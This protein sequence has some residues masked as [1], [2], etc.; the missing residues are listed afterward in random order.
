LI[1]RIGA[2]AQTWHPPADGVWLFGSA[3][4]GEGGQD[5]D[6]DLLVIRNE[7]VDADDSLWLVQLE[8]LAQSVASWTGNDCR[9][10]EYSVGEIVR[11]AGDEDP[12]ARLIRSEGI[13]ITGPRSLLAGPRPDRNRR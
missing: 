13:R 5:S 8:R 3:A 10:V 11:L 9:V 1:G 4:R 2:E 6:V 7:S 12:L